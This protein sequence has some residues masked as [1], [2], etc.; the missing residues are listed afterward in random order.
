[1]P[2]YFL[3][4]QRDLLVDFLQRKYALLVDKISALPS[5][6]YYTT[7][8]VVTAGFITCHVLSGSGDSNMSPERFYRE[9]AP[10]LIPVDVRLDQSGTDA[11]D[12]RGMVCV[13]MARRR[14]HESTSQKFFGYTTPPCSARVIREPTCLQTSQ[15]DYALKGIVLRR[16]PEADAE[17]PDI[18]G[19]DY[20]CLSSAVEKQGIF[21]FANC[22]EP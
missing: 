1:V 8:V 16:S 20:S 6:Y 7:G 13:S 3:R 5:A 9:W 14:V 21:Q 4:R 2:L 15:T 17:V 19:H 22:V 18:S 11:C 10:K 12:A